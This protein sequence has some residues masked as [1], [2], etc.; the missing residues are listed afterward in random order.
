MMQT[1]LITGGA[2]GLGEALAHHYA[3]QD[4]EVCIVDLD[5]ERSNEVVTAINKLQGKAFFLLCDITNDTDIETLKTTASISL[6]QSGCVDQQ[7]WC[8]HGRC[9][10]I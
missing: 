6:G 3:K 9:V 10:G 4:F 8:C 1:V 2:S 7:C 5:S